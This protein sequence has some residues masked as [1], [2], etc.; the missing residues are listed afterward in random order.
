MGHV[1]KH[2][3]PEMLTATDEKRLL[4]IREAAA[5]LNVSVR[6]INKWL[7][8]GQLRRVKL[9]RCTRVDRADI[10]RIIRDGGAG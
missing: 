4:T 8:T 1:R 5:M 10:D 2:G 9:G 6:L 7:S 3:A